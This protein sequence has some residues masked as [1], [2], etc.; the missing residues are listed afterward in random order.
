MRSHGPVQFLGST[1]FRGLR[2]VYLLWGG[3]LLANHALTN[4]V[5]LPPWLWNWPGFARFWTT[6]WGRG[7]LVGLGLVMALAALAEVWE[8]VDRMLT[9][10]MHDRERES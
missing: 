8:L 1:L 5:T 10:F 3:I 6:P 9:R 7:I 4:R 2:F